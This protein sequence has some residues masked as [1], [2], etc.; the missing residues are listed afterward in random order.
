MSDDIKALRMQNKQLRRRVKELEAVTEV[1]TKFSYDGE[2]Y[3]TAPETPGYYEV[4]RISCST[5]ILWIFR[6]YEK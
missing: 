3:P 1:I 5:G 6:R 4:D 2:S